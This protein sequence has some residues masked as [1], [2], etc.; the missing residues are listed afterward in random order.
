MPSLKVVRNVVD[1]MKNLSNFV[2]VS[3]NQ[4][5]EMKLQV[6]TD[7]VA[8][9]TYFQDLEQPMW[10]KSAGCGGVGVGVDLSWV[11]VTYSDRKFCAQKRKFCTQN[12]EIV[13]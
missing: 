13:C 6:E 4:N 11:S 7:M 9:G 10:S 3:A 1:R 12:I 8:V 2:T 5:G